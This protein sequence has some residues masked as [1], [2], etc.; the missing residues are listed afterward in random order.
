MVGDRGSA[1][2]DFEP[3][4]ISKGSITSNSL[5]SSK[6]NQNHNNSKEHL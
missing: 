3:L 5:S 4:K 1:D 6:D 2:P